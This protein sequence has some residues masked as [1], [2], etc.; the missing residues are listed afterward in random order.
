MGDG[1]SLI[2]QQQEMVQEIVCLREHN[3]NIS[4]PAKRKNEDRLETRKYL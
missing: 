4:Q 3:A 2:I 1:A